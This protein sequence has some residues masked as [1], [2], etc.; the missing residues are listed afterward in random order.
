LTQLKDTGAIVTGAGKGIGRAL[1]LALLRE[2]VN[3]SGISRTES[4]LIQIV[5]KAEEL[6]GEF[7]AYPGDVADEFFIEACVGETVADFDRI[8]HLINNA[9]IG[10]FKPV[11]EFSVKEWDRLIDTNLRGTFL[12]TKFTL[13]HMIKKNSGTIV[14]VS[15][16]A[17]KHAFEGGAAYCASKFAMMG[18]SKS[19]MFDVRKY[20][21]RVVTICP[22]SVATRFHT[23]G[24]HLKDDDKILL[25]ED[26]ASTILYALTLPQRASAHEIELRITNP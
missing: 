23:R 9:G 25:P 15:S 5:G 19:V 8:D 24:D 17:G 26:C 12:T 20:N 7:R 2:G 11:H 14:N 18:F 10:L 21:I 13:P 3:V 16:I 22:G 4:D 1:T 6:P